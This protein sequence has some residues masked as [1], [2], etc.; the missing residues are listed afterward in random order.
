VDVSAES[1]G[2][3]RWDFGPPEEHLPVSLITG[4]L[5]SGK[6]TVINGLLRHRT[7]EP[8]AIIV[9]EFGE[10][11]IDHDLVESSTDDTVLLRGG[12]LC[13]GVRGDLA[14]TLADLFFRRERG[15]IP[16]FTR[17][18][19]ESSGLADPAP[20]LQTLIAERAIAHRY[21][22]ESVVATVDALN[23]TATLAS[24]HEAVK[25]V[26]IS[27]RVIL[28]KTDLAPARTERSVRAR[29]GRLNPAAPILNAVDGAITPGE[30]FDGGLYDPRAR[31]AD[32]L[33]WL[34]DEA[35][36]ANHDHR[37]HPVR[38]RHGDD[39]RA[40]CLRSDTPV[41][42]GELEEWLKGLLARLGAQVYRIKGIV[43][44]AGLDGPAV[45]H[46]VHHVL[47]APVVLSCW[48]S[49]DR[50]TR[51]VFIT[52]NVDEGEI[53]REFATLCARGSP[54]RGRHDTATG[55]GARGSTMG[56]ADG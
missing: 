34:R 32:V 18:L 10:V 4:F 22:L 50:R 31:S 38:S 11:G 19:I 17:V 46:G 1:A 28:T 48:P 24:R 42:L 37:D 5:G 39:T 36:A 29:L 16:T 41:G 45:I 35:Y 6:T 13:C 47:H 40:L 2:T 30:I 15:A 56:V 49:P 53:D 23:G 25:Q 14:E 43:N 54:A 7:I 33:G 9:N 52:R 3:E 12:C 26:S 27:D 55:S 8:T 51:I 21:R 44:V 20:I